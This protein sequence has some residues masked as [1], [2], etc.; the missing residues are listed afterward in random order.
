MRIRRRRKKK[1]NREKLYNLFSVFFFLF[2]E[3]LSLIIENI[4]I[5]AVESKNLL[6]DCFFLFFKLLLISDLLF[7]FFLHQNFFSFHLLYVTNFFEIA[8]K[9]GD[10][11]SRFNE[12]VLLASMIV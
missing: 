1:K 4:A 8:N 2:V 7:N 5:I 6:F 10:N 3:S 9:M 11:Y 12:L